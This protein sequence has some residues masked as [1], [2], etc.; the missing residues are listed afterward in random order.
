[1]H[2]GSTGE[3]N[4]ACVSIELDKRMGMWG[5]T[6]ATGSIVASGHVAECLLFALRFCPVNFKVCLLGSGKL[7]WHGHG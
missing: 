1:M 6:I 4:T 2:W 7:T 3:K 5:N